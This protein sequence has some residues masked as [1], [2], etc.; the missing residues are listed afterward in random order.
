MHFLAVNSYPR[1]RWIP[2]SRFVL[3]AN[4]VYPKSRCLLCSG[5]LRE[6]LP[7]NCLL[8]VYTC[9]R[10]Y[11]EGRGVLMALE[12]CRWPAGVCPPVRP[13]MC[14]SVCLY[15]YL[16]LCKHSYIYLH[17]TPRDRLRSAISRFGCLPTR[18][19]PAVVSFLSGLA[20]FISKSVLLQTE[21]PRRNDKSCISPRASYPKDQGIDNLFYGIHLN[22]IAN[23]V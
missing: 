6:C 15:M 22:K 4:K 11:Y 7:C 16:A 2:P 9:K 21:A 18:F 20:I 3:L 12:G 23:S 5:P 14:L 17:L 1:R 13:S 8:A 10:N 19:V